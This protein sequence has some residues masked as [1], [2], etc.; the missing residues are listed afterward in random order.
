MI[1]PFQPNVVNDP[2]WHHCLML[3]YLGYIKSWMH[4]HPILTGIIPVELE[5]HHVQG[6]VNSRMYNPAVAAR[7][8]QLVSLIEQWRQCTNELVK[9][10]ASAASPQLSIK[11]STENP[12]ECPHTTQGP[13]KGLDSRIS[14]GSPTKNLN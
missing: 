5:F 9:N 1:T 2:S 4:V 6:L 13:R 14:S 3:G 11:Q 7:H 10:C 8:S 12:I